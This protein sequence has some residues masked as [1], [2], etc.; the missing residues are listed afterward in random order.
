MNFY[1]LNGILQ[2]IMALIMI[3]CQTKCLTFKSMS[4]T[5]QLKRR[6]AVFL[7]TGLG[8]TIIELA[9]ARNY[10][11]A[12]NKPVLII[13]PFGCGISVFKRSYKV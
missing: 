12:T 11:E 7:D 6:E 13:T 2:L 8:K 3:S 5:M 1:K 9:T 4:L 10:I